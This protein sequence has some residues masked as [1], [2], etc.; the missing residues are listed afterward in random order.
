M[1]EGTFKERK[2]TMDDSSI[3]DLYLRRS[4]DAIAETDKKYGKR[5]FQASKLITG[6]ERDADECKND[7]YLKAWNSIPP[8]EPRDY[9]FAFLLRI[10]RHLSLNAVQKREAQKRNAVIVELSEEL[11]NCIPYPDDEPCKADDETL[12]RVINEFLSSLSKENR[13]I[14]MRRYF[15]SDSIEEISKAFG[16]SEGA[17]KNVLYRCRLKLS[18][19]LKK[20]G[21]EL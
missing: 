18:S 6:D 20:E 15:Y 4:E 19:R 5:L 10:I 17:V 7:T 14:F 11:E 13:M 2:K 12:G 8:H 21:I 16:K 1:G 9:L 3:V